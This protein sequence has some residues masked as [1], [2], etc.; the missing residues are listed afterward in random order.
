LV[1]RSRCSWVPHSR[2]QKSRIAEGEVPLFVGEGEVHRARTL[3]AQRRSGLQGLLSR[4]GRRGPGRGRASAPDSM[5]S[6]P[7]W[8]GDPSDPSSRR[9][10]QP[11]LA[12]EQSRRWRRRRHPSSST[13]RRLRF[14]A[15]RRRQLGSLPR[16][17]TS[18]G[19]KALVDLLRRL[20][21]DERWLERHV[22]RGRHR[23]HGVGHPRLPGGHHEGTAN[24]GTAR[25]P[26]EWLAGRHGPVVCDEDGWVRRSRAQSSGA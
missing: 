18:L 25:P 4:R 2:A 7:T 5:C 9:R 14:E 3:A 10:S 12:R 26:R 21:V 23:R 22:T 6:P 16:D 1:R 11:R 24:R 17:S 19:L 20:G 8:R 13:A 15:A